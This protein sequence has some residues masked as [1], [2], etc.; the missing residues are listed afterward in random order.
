M[1]TAELLALID[2]LDTSNHPYLT[3]ALSFLRSVVATNPMKS[4]AQLQERPDVQQA[5]QIIAKW[6]ADAKTSTAGL[7]TLSP[8]GAA[9]V[10]EAATRPTIDAV[11]HDTS[12][13]DRQ[14][15]WLASDDHTSWA[16]KIILRMQWLK[17]WLHK[18]AG[19]VALDAPY[20]RWVSRLDAS[21]CTFCRGLHGTV[22]PVSSSFMSTATALG[23]K[24]P[25]GGL[26]APPLHPRC[27]CELEAVSQAEH[28]L[29]DTSGGR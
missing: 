1:T 29:A 6:V 14:E 28:D 19:W 15:E 20:K 24:R 12:L 22:L 16:A 17:D 21:T 3:G 11:V 2:S 13:V 5:L 23:F 7:V 9:Q 8:V 27:R 26:F 10:I 4:A 25:Y 18:Q